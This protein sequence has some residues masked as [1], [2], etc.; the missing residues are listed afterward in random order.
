M[1]NK[2]GQ[3]FTNQ[4]VVEFM[5]DEMGF[6]DKNCLRKTIIDTACGDGAFLTAI[7]KRIIKYSTN[8]ESKTNLT[9]IHG[10]EIDKIQI[11]K[12]KEN[13]NKIYEMDWNI[14]NCDALI[15]GLDFYKDNSFFNKEKFDFVVGNPPYVSYN[16]CAKQKV[17][18]VDRIKRRLI[19][20]ANIYGV[21][22][23]STPYKLKSYPPK[24]NLYAFFMALG[25]GLLKNEGKICYIIPQTLLTANDLDVL[26]YHFAHFSTIEKII[27]FNGK[28]FVER[29]LRQN[30][31]I[32]TSSLVIIIK[33][34][35]CQKNHKIEIG[36]FK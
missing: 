13:L 18:I 7:A 32:P 24:P 11:E 20:M 6:F 33:K 36:G 8:E 35:V 4:K 30:K 22:L 23:N 10:W 28:M 12:C 29:G 3:V 26:R 27:T 5:L 31:A 21:N 17:K 16:E 14:E 15:E 2:L 9:F 34:S 19:N 1:Q 25:F